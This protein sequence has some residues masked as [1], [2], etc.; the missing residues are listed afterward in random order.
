MFRNYE[1]QDIERVMLDSVTH[2]TPLRDFSVSKF[3]NLLHTYV[4][5][6]TANSALACQH[7]GVI[8]RQFVPNGDAEVTR[9][10]L[11]VQVE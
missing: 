8:L 2:S 3:L 5:G 9:P 6:I 11:S 4:I 10:G 7:A 1:P